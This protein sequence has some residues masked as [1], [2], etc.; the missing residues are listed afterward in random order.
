MGLKTKAKFYF[1]Y[2]ITSSNSKIDFNEGAGELT[3]TLNIGD[4]SMSEFTAEV[5]AAINAVGT[6]TYTVTVDRSTRIITISAP[7]TFDL[8]ITSGTNS[9]TSV[10]SAAGFT[11][12]D[13]TGLTTYSGVATGSEYIPQFYLKDYLPS[14]NN[15]KKTSS[16]RKESASGKVEVV[17]YG[18]VSEVRMNITFITDVD[19]GADSDVITNNPTGV[20]NARDFMNFITDIKPVEFM[21]DVATP[22]TF[23]KLILLNTP[24]SSDGVDYELKELFSMGLAEYYET[25]KLTYRVV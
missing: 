1:G 2:S 4:F 6:Q 14:I 3:G 25:G 11:G 20:Q 18:S 22:G 9:D 10:Y 21:E 7:G 19:Q 12:A 16:T 15:R 13:V 24:Q 23:E 8:L 5:G 17:S